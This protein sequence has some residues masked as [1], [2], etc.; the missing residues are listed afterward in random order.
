MLISHEYRMEQAN[1]TV[2]AANIYW[3]SKYRKQ[4][5]WEQLQFPRA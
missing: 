4:A 5:I 2:I 3:F 1:A